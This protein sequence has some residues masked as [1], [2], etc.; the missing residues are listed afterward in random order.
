MC[1][2]LALVGVSLVLDPDWPWRWREALVLLAL[3]RWR[4]PDARLLLGLGLMPGT[5]LFYDMTLT[6]LIARTRAQSAGLAVLSQLGSMVT[7]GLPMQP[8]LEA[9]YWMTGTV[10]LWTVLLPALALVLRRRVAELHGAGQPERAPKEAERVVGY[11]Q[12]E[13]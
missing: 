5:G 11:R 3:W 13:G 8:T 12:N 9:P 7:V 10:V 2:G 1:G 4:D 6:C